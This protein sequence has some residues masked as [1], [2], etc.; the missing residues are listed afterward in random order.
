[1][2]VQPLKGAGLGIHEEITRHSRNGSTEFTV[3]LFGRSRE[4]ERYGNVS[5]SFP[6]VHIPVT[7]RE[8]SLGT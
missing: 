7:W 1:M 2:I 5:N 4:C 8:L 3:F 6:N